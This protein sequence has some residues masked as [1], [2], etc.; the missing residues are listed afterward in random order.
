M[1]CINSKLIQ[2]Y[3][4]GEATLKQI[5]AIEK[6]LEVCGQCASNIAHQRRLAAAV[7]NAVHLLNVDAV[8]IPLMIKK[9]HKGVKRH[10]AVKYFIYSVSAACILFI[11]MICNSGKETLN[12]NKMLIISDSEWEMDANRPLTQQQLILNVI[13]KEGN[14]TEYLFR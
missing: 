1:S 13:D 11:A 5:S 9:T 7:K 14:V 6:H 8:Q 12:Q 3:I 2:I 4:D 10:T